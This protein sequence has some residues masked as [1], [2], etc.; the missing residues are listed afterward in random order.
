MR[1]DRRDLLLYAVTDRR[2]T[3]AQSL[4]QQVE[5]ALKGGVTCIQL[6][7][8]RLARATLLDEALQLRELCRRYRVPFFVNDCIDL[9]LAC[10]ADG[11]H[12][13]QDDTPI[14]EVRKLVG[15]DL[16]VGVSAHTVEE[17]RGA[18]AGGADYL[19]VGAVFATDT[20]ADAH[21]VSLGTL[22]DICQAVDV[23]AVAIGGIDRDNITK[24]AGTGVD[25]VAVVSAIFGA[26]DIKASCRDLLGR[27]KAMV[28]HTPQEVA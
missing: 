7:E 18:V 17:A 22:R 28:G 3:G 15:S 27:S 21:A 23:P 6:R 20:K 12:V 19:G 2:W 14:R 9:A 11:V 13:G 8:K 26:A 1:L 24:L 25:G 10:G 5:D 16:L 4:Y